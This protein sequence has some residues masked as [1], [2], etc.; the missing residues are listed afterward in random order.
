ME[1]VLPQ[2]TKTPEDALKK[3]KKKNRQSDCFPFL[4]KTCKTHCQ[5]I[6]LSDILGMQSE[7]FSFRSL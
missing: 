7:Q 6:L 2:E 4:F 1:Q 3:K 5:R